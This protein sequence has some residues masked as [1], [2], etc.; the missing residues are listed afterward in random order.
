MN[1]SCPRI[2]IAGLS[3]DSGKTVMSVGLVR[4]WH[5]EGLRVVPFKKGPDYID[6]GW[7]ALAAG[8]PC[9]NLDLFFVEKDQIL[10]SFV[11]HTHRAELTVIEG[12]RGIYDGLDLDGSVSTA[13]LAKL[14]QSPVVLVVDCTKVT[15]TAAAMVLGCKQ[16]DPKVAIKG[17]I[18]NQV[19]TGRHE[20]VIRNSIERFTDLPVFGSVPRRK[21]VT[22]PG[23]HLGLV[24][25]QEHPF[26]EQ[27]VAAAAEVAGKYLELDGLLELAREAPALKVLDSSIKD[28]SKR[29]RGQVRIGVIRDCAFQFYYQENLEELSR[30]GA[31]LLEISAIKDKKLPDLDA[32][33]IGGGFPETYAEILSANGS[34][35]RSLHQLAEAGLPIYAE[36]GGLMYLGES[37]SLKGHN[38]P[39]AGVFPMTLC[40]RRRPQGHGYTV[41]KVEKPN[42]YFPVGC[43]L[44]GHEFHYSRPLEVKFDRISFVFRVE[45]GYGFDGKRDGLCYKNVLATYSHVHALGTKEWA[46][47]LVQQAKAYKKKKS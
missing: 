16:F 18:L 1:L 6:M 9:Y 30:H 40:L 15:R 14:L 31:K 27:A 11:Q 17:V 5:K 12:N 29:P 26:A 47:A 8:R 35:R 4:A 3:G 13:E 46:G 22:F 42:P 19:A 44:R 21:N 33:Y 32:L 43:T 20:S 45:R 25:P 2:I 34:F 28:L 36:C 10:R 41:L 37:L 24:P 38:Y 23:R 39:M 7:L